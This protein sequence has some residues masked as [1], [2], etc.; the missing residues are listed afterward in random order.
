MQR[1]LEDVCEHIRAGGCQP[2]M[3]EAVSRL[4]Y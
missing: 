4:K 1:R 2:Q 3:L